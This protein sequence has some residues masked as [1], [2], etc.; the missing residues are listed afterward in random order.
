MLLPITLGAG[1]SDVFRVQ[2][3]LNG[4]IQF[5]AGINKVKIRTDDLIN[6]AQSRTLGTPVP[7]NEIL[8]LV[9]NCPSN[10][11]RLI[12]FD[13]DT[14]SNIVTIGTLTNLV[15]A[16]STTRR[17]IET[18]TLLTVHDISTADSNGIVSGITGGSFYYSGRHNIGTNNCPTSFSGQITGYLGTAFPSTCSSNVC[19][20]VF[21]CVTSNCVTN[22]MVVTCDT[23]CFDRADC[24]SFTNFPCTGPIDVIIARS[25]LNTG[26]AIGTLIEEDPQPE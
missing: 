22:D 24:F 25:A 3:T 6:L 21:V 11:F 9:S 1:T 17:R 26:K 15:T 5:G 18:M 20:N 7:N 8:A 12:V 16:L 13:T 23:N 19:S 14:S 10:D 4:S 2:T